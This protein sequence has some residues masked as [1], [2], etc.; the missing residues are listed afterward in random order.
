MKADLLTI[1]WPVLTVWRSAQSVSHM[2][3]RNTSEQRRPMA[4]SRGM[5]VICLGG[6]VERRDAPVRVHGEDAVRDA[7]QDRARWRSAADPQGGRRPVRATHR[8][9]LADRESR[10]RAA[11]A[12]GGTASWKRLSASRQSTP[13]GFEPASLRHRVSVELRDVGLDVEQRRAVE[14]VEI[15]D[16]Q[17]CCPLRPSRRTTERPIGLGRHGERVAKSPRSLV[18][19]YGTTRG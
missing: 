16:P 3:A 19:R 1:G 2:L 18:S 4:S 7:L 12:G 9:R 13:H 15:G 14:D 5:P 8:R 17:R 11:P 6:A 10:V